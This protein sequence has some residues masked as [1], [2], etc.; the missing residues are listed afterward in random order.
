[1]PVEKLAYSIREAVEVTSISRSTL[2]A[3]IAKGRLN[4]I[5]IGGRRL[6]PASSLHAFLKGETS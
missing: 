1:M 3:H 2:Y 5:R 6:I 4:A